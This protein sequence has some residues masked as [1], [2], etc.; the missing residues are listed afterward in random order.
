MADIFRRGL[1]R[2][3]KGGIKC[4]CCK[5]TK[6]RGRK[7]RSAERSVRRIMKQGLKFETETETQKEGENY[8]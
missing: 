1:D 5:P 8:V 6:N 3:G 2:C 7:N 4:Y